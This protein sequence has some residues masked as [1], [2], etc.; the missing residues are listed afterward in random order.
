METDTDSDSSAGVDTVADTPE[1]A[2]TPAAAPAETPAAT[3]AGVAGTGNSG[4]G[5]GS[6]A[7][8][9]LGGFAA[10]GVAAFAIKKLYLSPSE[11]GS[12]VSDSQWTL[13]P[14]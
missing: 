12:D 10:V 7:L 14:R 4:D 9:V 11:D 2:E 6:N 13:Q 8:M 3:P 5:G 1:P